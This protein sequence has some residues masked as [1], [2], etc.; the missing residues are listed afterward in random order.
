[1]TLFFRFAFCR[2]KTRMVKENCFLICV[3]F[4][5][6]DG[7]VWSRATVI[8]VLLSVYI[9]YA[10]GWSKYNERMRKKIYVRNVPCGRNMPI[11]FF[12]FP[13]CSYCIWCMCNKFFLL[14]LMWVGMRVCILLKYLRIGKKYLNVKKSPL[15]ERKV[16]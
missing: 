1:M 6:D 11:L 13:L 10:R 15:A 3:C 12:L 14:I 9:Y 16:V 4:M 7:D 2:V 5:F 8:D